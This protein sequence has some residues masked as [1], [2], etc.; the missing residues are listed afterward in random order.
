MGTQ[1]HMGWRRVYMPRGRPLPGSQ[2]CTLH[3]GKKTHSVLK[4]LVSTGDTQTK[5]QGS[6]QRSPSKNQAQPGLQ[7]PGGHLVPSRWS[8]CFRLGCALEPIAVPGAPRTW[9][10]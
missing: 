10:E 1:T 2:T 8:A 7:R 3:N 4:P 5:A 6:S 9:A